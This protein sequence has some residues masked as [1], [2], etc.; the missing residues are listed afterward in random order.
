MVVSECDATRTPIRGEGNGD[1]KFHSRYRFEMQTI[2]LR[3]CNLGHNELQVARFVLEL[4][5]ITRRSHAK[6]L[7]AHLSFGTSTGQ[8]SSERGVQVLC[9]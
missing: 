7:Q 9:F 4:L 1:R 2:E 8:D 5:Y 6:G 3:I